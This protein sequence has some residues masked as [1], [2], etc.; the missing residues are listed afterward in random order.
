MNTSMLLSVS[1]GLSTPLNHD[2][3]LGENGTGRGP[4]LPSP[5]TTAC[6]ICGIG[7]VFGNGLDASN[8]F[9]IK[10]MSLSPDLDPNLSVKSLL[11]RRECH[12]P[13]PV[14]LFICDPDLDSEAHVCSVTVRTA[15]LDLIRWLRLNTGLSA[16]TLAQAAATHTSIILH[17]LTMMLSL[18]G[19]LASVYR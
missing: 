12:L 18:K 3:R 7:W 10:A 9:S 17:R 15:R 19:S 2:P 16:G 4:G 6:C 1:E 8:C 14:M 5:W 13:R 11:P